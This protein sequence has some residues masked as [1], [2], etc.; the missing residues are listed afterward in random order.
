MNIEMLMF[1][2]TTAL[3]PALYLFINI[4][5]YFIFTNQRTY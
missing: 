4:S 3:Q 5:N 1:N 2:R